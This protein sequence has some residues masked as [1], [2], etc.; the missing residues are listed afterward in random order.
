[1]ELELITL[2]AV[3][4]RKTNTVWHHS[5]AESKTWHKWTY[6]WNRRKD[7]EH[8]WLPWRRGDGEHGLGSVEFTSRV[9]YFPGP[10]PRKPWTRPLEHQ[11]E[12]FWG[13]VEW[14]LGLTGEVC[15]RQC[16]EQQHGSYIIATHE[17]EEKS[18][19]QSGG[20]RGAIP[21]WRS[22]RTVVRRYPSSKVRS[23]GCTLL[24]QPWRDT[25]R[26]R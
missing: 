22:G 15:L 23:S 11:K 16:I 5:Y 9:N 10:P 7:R 20:P 19:F 3:S 14:V 18:Y 8:T 17:W 24:E 21:R 26:P 4:Q 6:L 1:M 13:F 2:S 12:K 25:P